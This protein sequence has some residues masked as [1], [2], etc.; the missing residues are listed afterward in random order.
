M[1]T[2]LS[3]NRRY[4]RIRLEWISHKKATYPTNVDCSK[5]ILKV[6]IED[7]PMMYVHLCICH[8]APIAHKTMCRV[9]NANMVLEEVCKSPLDGLN[10]VF[11]RLYYP[12]SS[13][14]LINCKTCVSAGLRTRIQQE[15]KLFWCRCKQCCNIV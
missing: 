14:P 2:N 13:S 12:H 8:N 3:K 10:L 11:W 9:T 5:E 4:R 15:P 7:S 6:D 1:A